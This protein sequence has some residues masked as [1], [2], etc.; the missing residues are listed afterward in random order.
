MV[1][2]I[3]ASAKCE[4]RS[5][6]RFFQAEGWFVENDQFSCFL[7]HFTTTVKRHSDFSRCLHSCNARLHSTAVTQQLLEQFEINN[8]CSKSVLN[9]LIQLV[10]QFDPS[11][12]RKKHRGFL[13]FVMADIPSSR[14]P[15]DVRR[16][17]VKGRIFW[18]HL[19]VAKVR[20]PGTASHTYS[21]KTLFPN[22]RLVGQESDVKFLQQHAVGPIYG[23]S[24]MELGFK[25]GTLRPRSQ[26]LT[27]R[28]QQP[29]IVVG[30]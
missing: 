3:D 26:D 20:G 19:F 21:C 1:G 18:N 7:S 2:R 4:L 28:P 12:F 13:E 29:C 30:I 24:S 9:D 5:V 6:N 10:E 14:E 22:I 8:T 16:Y 25:P 23:E 15:R 11:P 27:P 17:R